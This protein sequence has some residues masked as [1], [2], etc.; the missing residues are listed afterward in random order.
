MESKIR[1]TTDDTTFYISA[2]TNGYTH[3][4]NE[5]T[6]KFSLNLHEINVGCRYAVYDLLDEADAVA[7]SLGGVTQ[8]GWGH[9]DYHVWER[10]YKNLFKWWKARADAAESSAS[11][12]YRGSDF[13]RTVFMD[14]IVLTEY[15]ELRGEESKVAPEV[16][17]SYRATVIVDGNVH[18]FDNIVDVVR[19]IGET[20][21]ERMEVIHARQ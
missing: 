13:V 16:H 9:M 4:F 1:P 18:T 20:I 19:C 17:A 7:A 3:Y 5:R 10:H 21:Q 2:V 14:G 11:L 12:A 6:K 15:M 8:V